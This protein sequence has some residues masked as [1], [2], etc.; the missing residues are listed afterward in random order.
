MGKYAVIESTNMASTRYAERIYD[1]VATEDI[2]NGTV[3]YIEDYVDDEG[4]VYA[5]NKGY[6][7]GAI[8]V[9]VDQVAW[10][11]DTT[12]ISKQRKDNFICK[13]GTP[14]RV[15]ALK[16]GDEFGLTK[17]GFTSATRDTLA[18][19]MYVTID[20]TT[21]KLVVEESEPTTNVYGKIIKKELRG[22]QLATS[23]NDY[24]YVSEMYIVKIKKLV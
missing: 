2:E 5:F 20:N 22:G 23:A 6:K 24:G 19:D 13:A 18:K 17:E 11:Y 16:L 10:D 9:I 3:G 7:E 21:G 1:A 8:L 12:L 4:V 14:F 15:R